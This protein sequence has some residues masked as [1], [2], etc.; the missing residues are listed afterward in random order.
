M[1]VGAVTSLSAG[2]V[3]AGGV[4]SGGA[5]RLA[6]FV[7]LISIIGVVVKLYVRSYEVW[8]GKLVGAVRLLGKT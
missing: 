4:I 5:A 3:T 6:A 8:T 2:S 1:A 7:F